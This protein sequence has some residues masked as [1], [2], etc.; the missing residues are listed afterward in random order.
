[1]KISYKV[2]AAIFLVSITALTL[3][4]IAILRRVSAQTEADYVR[5]Y[6][7]YSQKIGDTL[8]QLDAVTELVMTN[9]AYVLREK[10]ARNGLPSTAELKKLRDELHMFNLYV[11]DANG[12]YIR[13]TFTWPIEKERP[14][15]TYCEDYRGLI[16]GRS[17]LAMTPI[18]RA[19]DSSWP[20]KYVMIPNHDRTRVL[21]AGVALNFV[22]D[23]LRNAIKPDANIVSIGLFTP[24][25]NVIGYVHSGGEKAPSAPPF[26][27]TT[28]SFSAPEASKSG[29]VFFSKVATTMEDCC[30]CRTKGLTLPDGKYFYVL[31]TEISRA[32]LDARLA[33]F[34]RRFFAV[35]L[36]A[37][38]LSAFMAYFIS[39]HLV[40]RLVRMG[41]R[42]EQIARSG[43]W[44]TRLSMSGRDEAGVL[45]EK[46]DDML[47]R[48]NASQAELASAEKEK[49]LFELARQVAHDIRS[50]LAA[51]VSVIGKAAQF[52]EDDRVL[53]RGAV[54]RINDIANS[55]LEKNRKRRTPAEDPAGVQ[56]LSSLID[57]LITEK[58][59]QFRSKIG[60]AIH[61][62]IDA[63]SYGAFVKVQA[64]EF[65]RVLSNL[66]NNAVEALGEKGAVTVILVA[67]PERLRL[68]IRDTGKGIPPEILASLGR[69]DE[70]YGKADGT[71]LGLYHAR[72]AAEAWGGALELRSEVGRGT[73][74][75]LSLP[76]AK[77]P[78]WFVS[79]LELDPAGVVVMLDDD[80]S[81]HQIWRGRFESAGAK[82]VATEHFSTPEELTAWVESDAARAKKAVYLVDYELLGRKET[83]LSLIAAL[84]LSERAIL[85]TSRFE[86]P[87]ILD[88]CVR[89]GARMIPKGLAGFVP[90]RVRAAAD[91]AALDAVLIDDDALARAVWNS[92][93]KRAGKRFRAYATAPSFLADLDRGLIAL[94]KD[95]AL[96]LDSDLADGVKGEQVAEELGRMGFSNIRLA[97]GYDPAQ[98]AAAAYIREVVGKEPPWA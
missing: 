29:F 98:I 7:N 46:F 80:T 70:T 22:G 41:E 95:A 56:L 48:L 73:T 21:E 74:A 12:R 85:V 89:L 26:D 3:S 5:Q 88:E 51:L 11:T 34:R 17:K 40:S 6:R 47:K 61:S 53:V 65:Q 55:L 94:P 87:A 9:A 30:E 96:Y 91:S 69:R 77:A 84:G 36:L 60:V 63:D 81:I 45:A 1:M 62:Q 97:T 54:N 64:A 86:E 75:A 8:N 76:R 25:G 66:V 78:N 49:A 83:G 93:A 52:P 33:D 24:T 50:P 39:R 71:G 10:E 44:N 67:E 57:P 28:V 23:T 2:F 79:E 42:L 90:I 32:S 59:M 19:T 15:F 92:A 16:T 37:L 20:F 18:L 38:A 27:A 35:G 13:S 43:N 68:E 58:R 31:R 4:E 82:D 14:L 72:T